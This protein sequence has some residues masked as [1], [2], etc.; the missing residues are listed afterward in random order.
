MGDFDPAVESFPTITNRH[1][2]KVFI[3]LLMV[4]GSE[5]NAYLAHGFSDVHDTAHMRALTRAFVRAGYNV[6]VWD[7]THS[8]GRSEGSSEK[9]SFYHHHEDLEDVVEW[10]KSQPWYRE[11]FVLAG[12][13]LGG[14]VAGTYA[15]AHSRQVERLALVSPVVSGPALKRWIPLPVRGWWRWRGAVSARRWRINRYSWELM[16]SVWAYDLLKSAHRLTMPVLI[17]SAGR[18]W[19]IPPRLMRRLYRAVVSN[20]KQLEIVPG[21]RHGF[22]ADWEMKRLQVVVGEWLR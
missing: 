20:E 6:I 7:A 16:R 5:R 11:R 10:S 13:S 9:A 18:D 12:H 19:L 3:K 2:L 15:A 4:P 8:W 17:V 1:G 14:M 21:A 22:D